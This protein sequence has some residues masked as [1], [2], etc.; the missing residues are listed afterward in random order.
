MTVCI[1]KNSLMY[2]T[3]KQRSGLSEFVL[4]SVSRDFL[5]KYGRL[6]YLDELPGSDSSTYIKDRMKVRNDG[7]AKIE[8]ILDF[9]GTQ[10]IP[11]AVISINNNYRDVETTIIPINKDA[12]VNIEK[13]PSEFDDSAT[14]DAIPKVVYHYANNEIQQFVRQTDN[15]FTKFKN[16][17]PNAI[18]FTDNPSPK[19]GTTL[20]RKYRY[21][22]KLNVNPSK[23]KVIYGTKEDMHQRGTDY[24]SEV[25]QAEI[26]GYEA[27]R[28]IGLDDNQELNQN[29]T[30]IFDP[31]K[32]SSISERPSWDM[33]IQERVV[34]D[35][36][37][38]SYL[39]F[40]NTLEKL[41][42]LYGITF[43]T[44]TDAELNSSRWSDLMPESK[45]VNAF[46][47][48]GQIYINIDRA[49]VDAP[50]HEM[51]HLFVGSMRFTNPKVYQQLIQLSERFPN[52][53]KLASQFSG[54]T[55]NDINEEIFITEIS[56]HLTGQKSSLAGIDEKLL[57]E[58]SYN[59]HRVLDSVLMGTDSSKTIT[60]DRLYTL[61]LKDLAFE[62]NSAIMTNNIPPLRDSELHRKLNNM[63]SDLMKEGKLEEICD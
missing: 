62:L 4:E 20:D 31:K 3:L 24:T 61:S 15:Y 55:R 42:N 38:N 52:Y 10:T 30:V 41:A 60:D 46:I 26:E 51:L 7:S 39:V 17:T 49:S 11:E 54:K 6:P 59:V 27:V 28:F 5:E 45:L 9:A 47:Y 2:Q 32:V 63:K 53:N 8:N 50:L 19:P 22:V 23:V 18:F 43:N 12:L 37:V 40:N 13:R 35:Q 57:Y 16:G 44:V 25:N 21:A 1:N 36:N 48:D 34:P 29:I 58:I 14:I 33:G 56:K